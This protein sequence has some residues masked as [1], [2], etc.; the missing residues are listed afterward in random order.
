[1]INER[2]K[3]YF[4]TADKS[5]DLSNYTFDQIKQKLL[6]LELNETK[7]THNKS[8]KNLGNKNVL[9]YSELFVNG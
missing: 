4:K 7:K 5:F 8:H 3:D 1:M 2:K 9:L 6:K